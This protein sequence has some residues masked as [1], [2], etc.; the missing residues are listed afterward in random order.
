MQRQSKLIEDKNK[1]GEKGEKSTMAKSVLPDGDDSEEIKTEVV[2][3]SEQS[4]DS[5][6]SEDSNSENKEKPRRDSRNS[7]KDSYNSEMNEVGNLPRVTKNSATVGQ[8]D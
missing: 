1:E 3:D 7:H 4:S 6:P 5:T 8:R 2:I